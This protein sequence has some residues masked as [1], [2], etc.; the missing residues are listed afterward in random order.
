MYLS[1]PE[2][3]APHAASPASSKPTS[4]YSDP[5]SPKY[6]LPGLAFF[7]GVVGLALLA[8]LVWYLRKHMRRPSTWR[9]RSW[10]TAAR[11]LSF[12]M[13][14]SAYLCGL[15][16]MPTPRPAVPAVCPP[17]AYVGP[18]YMPGAPAIPHDPQLS[19][20]L[21]PP[22]LEVPGNPA[23]AVCARGS[24]PPY[25]PPP[26]P[27]TPELESP[28][29]AAAASSCASALPA[30]GPPPTYPPPPLPTP[31]HRVGSRGAARASNALATS[32][33][34][35]PP[36]YQ[37]EPP[38]ASS[39]SPAH[40]PAFGASPRESDAPLSGLA[41]VPSTP[42]APSIPEAN[43]DQGTPG[44][45]TSYARA[46][47]RAAAPSRAV[48]PAP[49]QVVAPTKAPKKARVPAPCTLP[50]P[51]D[52]AWTELVP[53]PPVTAVKQPKPPMPHVR[54]PKTPNV[55]TSRSRSRSPPQQPAV[56]PARVRPATPRSSSPCRSS[57]TSSGRD[58]D[59]PF[60]PTWFQELSGVLDLPVSDRRQGQYTHFCVAGVDMHLPHVAID[61]GEEVDPKEILTPNFTP[62]RPLALKTLAKFSAVRS[63]HGLSLAYEE[64]AAIRAADAASL[65]KDGSPN[66]RDPGGLHAFFLPLEVMRGLVF[67]WRTTDAIS[68]ITLNDRQ[69]DSVTILL[70]VRPEFQGPVIDGDM[71][72][73]SVHLSESLIGEN[74]RAI[75]S[76][77]AA[78]TSIVDTF[79]HM[80]AVPHAR[81]FVRRLQ[82]SG[83]VS[84]PKLDRPAL[85]RS[86]ASRLKEAQQAPSVGCGACVAVQSNADQG[87]S[88]SHV[89]HRARQTPAT[90]HR[91]IPRLPGALIVQLWD[92]ETSTKIVAALIEAGG[93][94]DA[95]YG[96]V[97]SLG[98]CGHHTAKILDAACDDIKLNLG[99]SA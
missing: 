15:V 19:S 87:S 75:P 31:N 93:D 2:M 41:Q 83:R 47:E 95:M 69:T 90:Q 44:T 49:A 55:E 33:P 99:L 61:E 91:V 70:S 25:L 97:R 14:V 3:D 64:H 27:P 71:L 78:V 67:Q 89:S 39:S 28:T 45:G 66:L 24:P 10:L 43:A 34:G 36:A 98:V 11:G 22:G 51:R 63:K 54:R 80:I 79:R 88:S 52:P 60:H 74:G 48:A 86:A 76:Y 85:S 13:P 20:D 32:V 50:P 5:T 16:P 77:A 81:N 73:I 17:P 68:A 26:P 82:Q 53:T 21:L 7:S 62:G 46:A 4:P 1:P 59:V 57:S 84:F 56:L 29:D 37:P 40:G 38:P 96:A 12:P 6:N 18:S 94:H 8:L 72:D 58:P 92:V 30:P 23:T 65:F 9:F 42:R 35:A